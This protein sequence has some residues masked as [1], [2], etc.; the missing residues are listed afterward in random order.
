MGAQIYMEYMLECS[1]RYLMSDCNESVRY[2]VELEK[3]YSK[4]TSSHVLF[5]LHRLPDNVFANFLKISQNSPK[6][7]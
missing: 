3:I 2:K 7:V 6:I 4:S 5:L 1:T